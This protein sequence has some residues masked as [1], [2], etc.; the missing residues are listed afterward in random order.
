MNYPSGVS[1]NEY[2]IAGPDAEYT[3]ERTLQC[4]NG[5]CAMFEQDQDVELDLQAHR[6]EEWGDWACGTCGKIRDYTGETYV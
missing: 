1:G 5:D 4:W 3:A 2:Q 6:G